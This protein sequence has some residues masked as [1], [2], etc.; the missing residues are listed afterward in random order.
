MK[1]PFKRTIFLAIFVFMAVML[2]YNT[3]YHIAK[4]NWKCMGEGRIND[5]MVFKDTDKPGNLTLLWPA[6]Y[7]DGQ[8]AGY[9]VFCFYERDH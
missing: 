1:K 8:I 7:K 4:Y 5:F 3:P 6:I 2:Y 9:V